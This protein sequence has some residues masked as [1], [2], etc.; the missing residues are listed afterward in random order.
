MHQEKSCF[1]E[2]LLFFNAH[3]LTLFLDEDFFPVFRDKCG[4]GHVC[5]RD[6][7]IFLNT[8]KLCLDFLHISIFVVGFTKFGQAIYNL[9]DFA[10]FNLQGNAFKRM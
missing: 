2:I 3:F 6:H 9:A 1:F 10:V 7:T 5:N 4:R 8:S